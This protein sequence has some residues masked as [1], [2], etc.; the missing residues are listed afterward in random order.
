MTWYKDWRAWCERNPSTPD[1]MKERMAV[2]FQ[3]VSEPPTLTLREWNKPFEP[4]WRAWASDPWPDRAENIPHNS[5]FET[6]NSDDAAMINNE[7]RQK[8]MK[9]LTDVRGAQRAAIATFNN[10]NSFID[11]MTGHSVLRQD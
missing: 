2:A 7:Q 10:R 6:A 9:L 1:A 5:Q 11:A 3:G 8:P 4:Q